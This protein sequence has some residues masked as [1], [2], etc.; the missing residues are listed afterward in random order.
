MTSSTPARQDAAANPFAPD[1]IAAITRHMNVDHPDDNLLIVRGLGGK[2]TAT[3]ARMSGLDGLGADFVAVV[4][5][6]DTDVRVPWSRELTER[7]EVRVEVVR[8]YQEAC[9]ALGVEPRQ[10]GEH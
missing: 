9:A 4:D 6:A 1:V 2:D 7:R 8:L 5:G 3:S 10:E